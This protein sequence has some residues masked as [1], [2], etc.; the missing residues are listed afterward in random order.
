MNEKKFMYGFFDA[1]LSNQALWKLVCTNN[2]WSSRHG[3]RALWD[4]I[5]INSDSKKHILKENLVLNIACLEKAGK[6]KT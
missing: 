5:S 4:A 1:Y 6:L 3:V 2:N